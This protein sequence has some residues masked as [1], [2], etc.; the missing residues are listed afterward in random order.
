MS[1]RIFSPKSFI[2]SK[3]NQ[4]WTVAKVVK[5]DFIQDYCNRGKRASYRTGL[6]A[7]YSMGKWNFIANEQGKVSG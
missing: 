3:K 2:V 1:Q 7:E 5:T 4:S 6:N